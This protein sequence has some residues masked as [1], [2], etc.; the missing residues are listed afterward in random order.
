MKPSAPAPDHRDVSVDGRARGITAVVLV[1]LFIVLVPLTTTIAWV[2]RTVMDTDTYV[3][4][5]APLSDD[6]GVIAPESR[7]VTDQLYQT[8][9]VPTKVADV[10]PA[11]AKLLAVPIANGARQYVQQ[12]VT[13][14]LESDAF[15]RLW[16]RSN[17]FAH[18]Q[19][20]AVLRGDTTGLKATGGQV[21]LNLVPLLE[22]ALQNMQGFVSSWG[23]H[24]IPLPSVSGTEAPGVSCANLSA[25]LN[26]RLPS[27]CG[28][29]TLF[30]AH[31]LAV[32]QRAVRAFDRGTI[33]LV[34]LTPLVAAVE[35]VVA[36][37]RRRSLL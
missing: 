26:R 5:V 32:A 17:E 13:R 36:H 9:D 24:P 4:T 7:Q 11:N 18:T 31:N 19:L 37:R 22:A 30:R 3:T 29:L 2:H 23:R 20:V 12:A 10:L 15:Q 8:L 16:A 27:N 35:L 6:P 28:V 1:G 34:I 14:V 25:A 21:A 33:L